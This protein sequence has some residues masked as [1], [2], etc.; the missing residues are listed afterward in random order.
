[1]I[2]RAEQVHHFLVAPVR[3]DR[4]LIGVP[5]SVAP[6]V[7][8]GHDNVAVRGEELALEVERMFVLTVGTTVDPQQRRVSSTSSERRRLD[9]EAVDLGAVAA[10]RRE[11]FR[12]A[13]DDAV[14]PC[15]VV[16]GELA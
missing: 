3:E 8:H 10:R 9:D 4:L 5:S 14:Q 15:I 1:V 7:V 11:V 6:A 16:R 2:H 13:E 12:R